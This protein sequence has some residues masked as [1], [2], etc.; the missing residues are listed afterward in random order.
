M[1]L[2]NSPHVVDGEILAVVVVMGDGII[3]NTV[4]HLRGG[5]NSRV[6]LS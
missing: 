3:H 4:H 6:N 2:R 1:Y 5:N